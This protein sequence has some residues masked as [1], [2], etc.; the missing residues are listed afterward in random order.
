M[1]GTYELWSKP[2]ILLPTV[3]FL[4]LFIRLRHCT[5]PDQLY[6]SPDGSNAA[7]DV[8]HHNAIQ[9]GLEH[10]VP[11]DTLSREGIYTE[12][13]AAPFSRYHPPEYAGRNRG[14]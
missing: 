1:T 4:L 2:S 6:V 10:I 5:S 9:F 13:I 12:K 14:H 7:G 11:G 3:A 8:Y